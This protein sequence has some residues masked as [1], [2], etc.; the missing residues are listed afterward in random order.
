MN[1]AKAAPASRLRLPRRIGKNRVSVAEISITPSGRH[2]TPTTTAST[3]SLALPLTFC[4]GAHGA[5]ARTSAKSVL[6][7]GDGNN[8]SSVR[9]YRFAENCFHV[10]GVSQARGNGLDIFLDFHATSCGK[11]SA[12][13]AKFMGRTDERNLATGHLVADRDVSLAE[14]L[15]R[16]LTPR[17]HEEIIQSCA[18]YRT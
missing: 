17:A 8:C 2:S 4:S 9:F 18:D 14:V 6:H 16:A 11:L 12:S 10:S 3:F 7:A 15:N 13:R 1:P 5:T